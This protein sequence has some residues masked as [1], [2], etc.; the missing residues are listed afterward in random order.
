[1]ITACIGLASAVIGLI[2]WFLHRQDLKN[3]MQRELEG[4]PAEYTIW[5]ERRDE[6]LQKNDSDG[7]TVASANLERLRARKAYLLQ[8]LGTTKVG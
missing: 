8:R 7:L 6:A 2:M 5:K 3:K 1:M 4:I